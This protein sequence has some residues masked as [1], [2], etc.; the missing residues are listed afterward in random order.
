MQPA[1]L[2]NLPSQ[3]LTI[4]YSLFPNLLPCMPDFPFREP[5]VSWRRAGSSAV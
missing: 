3:V 4:Y 5:V 1:T 2:R